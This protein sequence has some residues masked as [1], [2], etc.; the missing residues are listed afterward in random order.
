VNIREP[1]LGRWYGQQPEVANVEV[2]HQEV[3]ELF[4]N[5]IRQGYEKM[6]CGRTKH[7]WPANLRYA[8][9]M[10]RPLPVVRVEIADHSE[11]FDRLIVHSVRR[12][13]KELK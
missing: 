9:D 11:N 6:V 3:L 8:T 7:P 5:R 2:T 10:K 13:Q 12:L 1:C 4:T